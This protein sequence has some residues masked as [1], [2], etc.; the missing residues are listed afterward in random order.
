LR[1]KK[2]KF[3]LLDP[4]TKRNLE[5]REPRNQDASGIQ[6]QKRFQNKEDPEMK[7]NLETRYIFKPLRNE[8]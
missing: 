3:F 8:F 4:R 5:R 1:H 7:K 2:R 6:K